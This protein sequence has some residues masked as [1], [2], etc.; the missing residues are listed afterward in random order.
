M[1]ENNNA[2]IGDTSTYFYAHQLENLVKQ[3]IRIFSGFY[4]KTS[5]TDNNPMGELVPVPCKYGDGSR[6][7]AQILTNNSVNTART[8][9]LFAAWIK[10][11][12]LD[13]NRRR[14]PNLES[15]LQVT[16][17]EIDPTTG[18]YAAGPG[19]SYEVNRLMP[20]PLNVE[21]QLDL[22]TSNAS[23]LW[24]LLEQV[25]LIFNPMIDIQ[26][27]ENPLDWTA[28]TTMSLKSI[29]YNARSIP[30]GTDDQYNVT[31]WTFSIPFNINPPAKIKRL[32]NVTTIVTDIGEDDPLSS[33]DIWGPGYFSELITSAADYKI[34]VT[35]NSAILLGKFGEII[36]ANGNVFPWQPVIDSLGSYNP[37]TTL[38]RLRPVG[39][40]SYTNTDVYANFTI[41]QV[42]GNK[43]NLT[44]V[45]NTLPKTNVPPIT[46]IIDPRVTFPNNGISPTPATGTRYLILRQI[47]PNTVA[48]G[49]FSAPA[50]SIIEWNGSNWVISFDSTEGIV[51]SIVQNLTNEKLYVFLAD[52]S[53]V[54]AL[55]GTYS[56]G[57]WQLAFYP[58]TTA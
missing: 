10:N 49:T 42:E 44:F 18:R 46:D 2:K 17:R 6:L 1:T 25:S 37:E 19:T 3:V 16:E 11:V 21:I 4:Y 34:N 24:Q 20:V 52:G 23:Q 22:V 12:E 40:V 33:V 55:E 47:I 15:Q 8:I 28:L 36:D 41:D 50:N 7:V 9:P 54:S 51:G 14:G 5:P 30:V 58:E 53:W 57:F 32:I 29:D 13:D 45:A 56:Q 48:W 35:G 26:I 31:T 43:I 39:D 27:N 38:L